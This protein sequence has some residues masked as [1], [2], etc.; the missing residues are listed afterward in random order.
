MLLAM[1]AWGLS[2]LQQARLQGDT[3]EVCRIILEQNPFMIRHFG[4]LREERFQA[5]ESCVFEDQAHRGCTNGV[6]TYTVCGTRAEGII[7]AA[8]MREPGTNGSFYIISLQIVRRRPAGMVPSPPV[9]PVQRRYRPSA[10][11]VPGNPASEA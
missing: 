2:N 6:Y 7:K 3:P 9:T 4:H 8:W 5:G 10:P 11:L 1:A